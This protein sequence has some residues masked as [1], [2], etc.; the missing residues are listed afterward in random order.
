MRVNSLQLPVL[1]VLPLPPLAALP[2]ADAPK[3]ASKPNIVFVFAADI[4]YGNL[5][6]YG[7]TKIKTPNCDRPARSD[8]T[9][10]NQ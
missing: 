7:A 6:C 9:G 10:A 5:G 1:T 2:A 8:A 3:S 4:R